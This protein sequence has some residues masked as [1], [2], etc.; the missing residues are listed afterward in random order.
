VLLGAA[1]VGSLA[2]DLVAID[3]LA[4]D[5]VQAQPPEDDP[6]NT[7]FRAVEGPVQ[8]DVP[9][10][11]LMVVAYGIVW[12][13]VFGYVLRMGMLHAR[14]MRDVARLERSVADAVGDRGARAG[15]GAPAGGT[16]AVDS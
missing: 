5:R 7:A 12:L 13:L 6:Q 11:T 16:P 14:T 8:E 9:G 10:G 1:V 15:G 3:L 4:S 2:I